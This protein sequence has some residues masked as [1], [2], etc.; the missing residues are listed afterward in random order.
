[1]LRADSTF[2]GHEARPAPSGERR[3]S[4][5]MSYGGRGRDWHPSFV[6]YAEAIVG[7]PNYAGMPAVRKADGDIDWT[8]PSNRKEGSQNWNG[9]ALRRD[10]WRA[11]AL[12][13]GIPL[14]GFWLRDAARANH[15]FG[16]KPCQTCG[17]VLQIPYVYPNATFRKKFARA[18]PD[19]FVDWL[20]LPTIFELAT[21]TADD[22]G[23]R[24]AV[25]GF[26]SLLRLSN[27][28]IAD[29]EDL[30]KAIQTD[31]VD[32]DAS[33]LSPGSMSNS[34]DRLDGFHTYNLCCRGNQDAGR[35]SSNMSKYIVDR[36]AYEHWSQ[37]DWA[38]A[39]QMMQQ[40][41]VG[42][43]RGLAPCAAKN[44]LVQLTADHV[45]PI[46]LGFRHSSHFNGLCQSCNSAK[47]NRM[48]FEDVRRL[49]DLEVQGEVVVSDHAL[50]LWR[51]CSEAV[52]TDGD[53]LLLSRVM[54]IN[55]EM[56]LRL[57]ATVAA[58]QAPVLLIP[59]LQLHLASTR[60]AKMRIDPRTLEL[61][62]YQREERQPGYAKKR[63]ERVLRIAFES[64]RGRD[65]EIRNVHLV[66]LDEFDMASQEIFENANATPTP[67]SLAELNE[68]IRR[69]NLADESAVPAT[70]TALRDI[71]ESAASA[72]AL[73]AELDERISDAMRLVQR[74]LTAR[75]GLG[76]HRFLG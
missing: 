42:Y 70:E 17:R 8:V 68:W 12:E 39:D 63:I 21:K 61:V 74:D 41:P 31:L 15:P 27:P 47:N 76:D 37:G 20:E 6:E 30:V 25:A 64:I 36:R 10:W 55:Q 18:F 24:R 9:N 40:M 32:N 19:V 16:A 4:A 67:E 23:D 29:L 34:P 3:E 53:A 54:R 5:A 38:V 73:A 44:H 58:S 60:V 22:V 35:S 43:C 69:I 66:Q 33:P 50:L 49:R 71:L 65:A 59:R 57:L 28:A 52:A 46:S 45:G 26:V 48:S 56:Y 11:K 75:F 2:A 7:H 62:G 51:E 14:A 72:G 1:M 13:F